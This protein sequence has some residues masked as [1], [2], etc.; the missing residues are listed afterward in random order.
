[1]IAKGIHVPLDLTAFQSENG[2]A[3][4]AAAVGSDFRR[5]LFGQDKAFLF[6]N[7]VQ[8]IHDLIKLFETDVDASET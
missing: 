3:Q 6:A 7:R 8:H 2:P 1:V 4:I 5:K